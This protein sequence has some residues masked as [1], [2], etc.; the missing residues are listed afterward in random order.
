MK[1]EEQ[2]QEK[3]NDKQDFTQ[4]SILKKLTGFMF[5]TLGALIL[6]AMYGAVD[7][8]IVGKFGTTAGIS[9]V[10]TGANI[11]NMFT[12]VL[13]SIAVGVTVLMGQYI[14]AKE[15]HKIGKLLGNAVAFFTLMAVVFTLILIILAGPIARLLQTPEEAFDLTVLYM[16]ICGGGFVFIV[17]YNLISG[18]FRGLGDSKMPLLFVAIA[19]VVNIIGDLVLVAGFHL[20]VAGAAIATVAAQAVSVILSLVIIR[21]KPLPFKFSVKD[22]KFGSEI[23]KFV[24]IGS[25]LALQEL[26]TSISFLALNAFINRLGLEAS[27]GYGVAQK[28]QQ[29]VMLIPSSLMQSMGP[30][31]AQNVGAKKED[32]ARNGM[33]CGMG[34]GCFIGV[35]VG[36]L[37]FLKG[38]LISRIF[39]DDAAVIGRSFEFMRGFAPEAVV[40][41]ILFSFMGYF[42]GH[43]KS[44]FVMAQGV[45]QSFLVRLPFSYIMSIQPDATLTGI[46]LAAPVATVFGIILCLI[47]YKITNK[48]D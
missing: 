47:Y 12:F 22:I 43:S 23:A 35:F 18:I 32:R 11:L 39:T 5:P 31:V 8:L 42:N 20:N 30:F 14:G 16:R 45:A 33:L 13:V 27:S 44:F 9:G 26:L 25:P 19:C 37:I 24:K 21:K 1:D 10:S 46:G 38:D 15:N 17:A 36:L 34:V 3:L 40:T 41:C 6:Q 28:I 48:A 4:G 2:I 7:L 29:F